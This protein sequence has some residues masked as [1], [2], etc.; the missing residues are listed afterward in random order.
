MSDPHERTRLNQAVID[1]GMRIFSKH[2]LD[3][4][5]ESALSSFVEVLGAD[6]G[7]IAL[8]YGR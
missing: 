2:T 6:A 1:I 8:V 4:V 5:M 3:E 7:H